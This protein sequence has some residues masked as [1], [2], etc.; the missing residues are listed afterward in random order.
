MLPA[1][2]FV[3]SHSLST[4]AKIAWSAGQILAQFPTL[5]SRSDMPEFLK[6]F[7]A[8]LDVVNLDPLV[9]LSLSCWFGRIG[10]FSRLLFATLAPL[11]VAAVIA[12]VRA[13]AALGSA[14]WDPR[15]EAIRTCTR[16]CCSRTS[17]SRR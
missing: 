12:P 10:F 3:W 13:R 11:G 8:S 14:T 7:Y 1:W 15:R 9:G 17:C 5:L 4:Q 16:A 6:R 2:E